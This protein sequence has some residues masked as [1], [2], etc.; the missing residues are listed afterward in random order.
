MLVDVFEEGGVE[1]AVVQPQGEDLV[2]AG[3]VTVTST[4]PTLVAAGAVAVIEVSLFTVNDDAATGPKSTAVA[5]VNPLPVTVTVVPPASGPL[6]GLTPVTT[7]A[8]MTGVICTMGVPVVSSL[9]EVL[10][11]A[12]TQKLEPPPPRR[13]GRHLAFC[14]ERAA[15]LSGSNQPFLGEHGEGVPGA[16]GPQATFGHLAH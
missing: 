8:V 7:G 13:P 3:V 11:A 10:V 14:D 9:I 15:P 1:G 12:G 6:D 16:G 2:P 4:A 5:P